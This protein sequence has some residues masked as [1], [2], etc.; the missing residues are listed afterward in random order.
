MDGYTGC[1]RDGNCSLHSLLTRDVHSPSLKFVKKVLAMSKILI[2]FWRQVQ[3]PPCRPTPVEHTLHQPLLGKVLRHLDQ[4]TIK[5]L[6]LFLESENTAR[7]Y[8]ARDT[9]VIVVEWFKP[10]LTRGQ[11]IGMA[12]DLFGRGY[13]FEAVES[14]H[15]R[16]G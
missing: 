9:E 5:P 14:E 11:E 6:S 4:R 7:A 16:Q 8:D 1:H 15:H 10:V 2:I 12:L 13:E 3:W